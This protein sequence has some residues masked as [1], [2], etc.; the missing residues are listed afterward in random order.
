MGLDQLPN[1]G[2]TP[3]FVLLG[4]CFT[5]KLYLFERTRLSDPLSW[6]KSCATRPM[7]EFP[8]QSTPQRSM[9]KRVL[10]QT[11]GPSSGSSAM[12][13][14]VTMTVTRRD[15]QSSESVASV[16]W[17]KR[18]EDR[19]TQCGQG[20]WLDSR[21]APGFE[22]HPLFPAWPPLFTT[23]ARQ[24]MSVACHVFPSVDSKRVEW[25]S[26]SPTAL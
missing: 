7:S 4:V 10:L 21:Q 8:A 14:T 20:V 5:A 3:K 24:I 1:P 13:A 23:T 25:V 19:P 17:I 12:Q 11:E 22:R 15:K 26:K 2:P 9:G 18:G 6:S 16:S